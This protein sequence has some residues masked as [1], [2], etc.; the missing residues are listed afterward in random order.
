[1]MMRMPNFQRSGSVSNAHVGRDF[2]ELVRQFFVE[3]GVVLEREF[4]IEIG[5]GNRRKVHRF[6]FGSADPAVLIE[7]KCHRWTETGKVPSAKMTV[8]NEAM[9]FFHLAPKRFRKIFVV[10][11]S[12]RETTSLVDHYVRCHGHLIPDDVELWEFDPVTGKGI[13]FSLTDPQ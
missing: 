2:G 12:M 6:D 8:W 13:R 11:R 4:P 7:C 5:I 3:H 1:M 10:E 9:Y